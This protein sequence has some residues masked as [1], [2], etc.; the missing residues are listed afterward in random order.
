MKQALSILLLL[1]IMKSYSQDTIYLHTPDDTI[2]TI[3]E[4]ALYYKTINKD[5]NPIEV[6][7]YYTNGNKYSKAHYSSLIPEIKEGEYER[8][9]YNGK[10]NIKGTF[11]NNKMEGSWLIYNKEKGFVESKTNFKDNVRNGKSF[12]FYENGKLS[13]MEIYSNDT[14]LSAICYDTIGNIVVGCQLPKDTTEIF[15]VADVMPEF[16]G[17]YQSVMTYLSRNIRYPINAMENGLQGKV[18]TKYYIDVDGTVKEPVVVK[19]T[20]GSNE[21]AE[22]AKRVILSMPKW[23]PG[24]KDGKNVRVNYVLPITFK[25]QT[26]KIKN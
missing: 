16:P 2:A 1:F 26:A 10:T 7:I 15:D 24:I 6:S 8:Y 11:I 25:I 14:L 12:T 23:T 20:T 18:I 13:R 17:G 9:F 19:N 4:K 22:E 3:K 21:C 5:V